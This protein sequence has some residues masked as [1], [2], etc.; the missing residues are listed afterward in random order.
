MN[1]PKTNK[2]CF[3]TCFVGALLVV[4]HLYGSIYSQI[5]NIN[6]I[7]NGIFTNH[8]WESRGN[9]STDYI[10]NNTKY[11]SYQNYGV[12]T[13][14]NQIGKIRQSLSKKGNLLVWGPGSDS[15]YWH[16]LTSGKVVFIE[17]DSFNRKATKQLGDDVIQK[18]PF[19]EVYHVHYKINDLKAFSK[20][21]NQSVKWQEL[22]VSDQLPKSFAQTRW[23][24]III[25][26]PLGCC[27]TN[28]GRYHSIYTSWKLAGKGAHIFV[29]DFERKDEHELSIKI[30]GKPQEVIK[31]KET[32]FSKAS[33]QAHFIINSKNVFK[34]YAAKTV[35]QNRSPSALDGK[36][37]NTEHNWSLLLTVNN[38]YFDFFKNWRLHFMKLNI[39]LPVY[40]IAEDNSVYDKL[41]NMKDSN[42]KVQRSEYISINST[43]RYDS[44]LYRKM[45][46]ARPTY[47]LSFLQKGMNIIYCD[48]DSVWL[49]NP[50][51]YLTGNYDVWSQVDSIPLQLFCT[52]FLAIKSNRN[53][54]RLVKRWHKQLKRTPN[55]NQPVFNKLLKLSSLKLKPLNTMLFPSGELYFEI[56]NDKQR[57]GAVVVH[58]NWIR[59]HTNKLERFQKMK[60]WLNDTVT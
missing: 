60:L 4:S 9:I 5:R 38:G 59:G 31:R 49:K 45:V 21:V 13:G 3:M 22:D 17:D 51:P 52:G 25:D 36:N 12:R 6:I 39:S 15:P 46:S 50:L 14:E 16:N 29:D 7:Q 48:L 19:L 24:V 41:I 26:A 37:N 27:E 11:F 34:P 58:N 54:Y 56:F 35:I 40:V 1:V 57:A 47:I 23:N 2:A 32:E 10:L 30:F 44:I 20:Y 33:T 55:L 28:P 18:Y 43:V 42:F 53:T 8:F